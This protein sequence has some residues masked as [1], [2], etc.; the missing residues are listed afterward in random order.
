MPKPVIPTIAEL[1][2]AL[3]ELQ[4]KRLALGTEAAALRAEQFDLARSDPQPE[5]LDAAAVRVAAIL[6]NAA[7]AKP[8]GG[9]E[10]LRQIA[11]QLRD[12]EAALLV[13]DTQIQAERSRAS[14]KVQALLEP[15]FR[16]RR[17]EV[18][19]ALIVAHAA[20]FRLRSLVDDVESH[21][22]SSGL[23]NQSLPYRFDSPKDPN[24]WVGQYLEQARRDGV[25]SRS[26]IPMELAQ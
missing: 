16:D 20:D 6:G 10:R 18:C 1:S 25:I 24:G 7:P 22:L 11:E 26:A 2:P 15:E 4:V 12:I 19:E 9:L 14:A 23:W 13:L 5:V 21:G 3:A 8:A 17:R